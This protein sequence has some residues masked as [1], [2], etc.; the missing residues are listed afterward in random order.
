MPLDWSCPAHW[1]GALD[2]CDCNCGIHDPDCDFSWLSVFNCNE[3]EICDANDQCA[4]AGFKKNFLLA[5]FLK[6]LCF[7]PSA[8]HTV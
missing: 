8:L 2:D 1:Y 3:N 5:F 6:F 7:F 4:A